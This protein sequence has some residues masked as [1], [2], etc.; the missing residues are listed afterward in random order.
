MNVPNNKKYYK[1][2]EISNHLG[3]KTSV[4]RF[5]EE[6]FPQLKIKKNKVSGH[7][8]YTKKDFDLIIKIHDLL[9][10]KNFKIEG[11]IKELS[12]IKNNAESEEIAIKKDLFLDK[13]SIKEELLALKKLIE[14]L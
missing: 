9:Y 12:T 8:R 3:I 7:R 6:K 5:W 13:N 11:A 1:I 14:N 4:L 10:N 2:G